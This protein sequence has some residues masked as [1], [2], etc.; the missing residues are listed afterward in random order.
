[1]RALL[2]ALI[3]VLI[4]LNYQLWIPENQGVRQMQMLQAAIKDQQAENE[5]LKQR[6]SGL[7]AE[8]N[9]LKE[10]L[11]AIEERAR[12]NLGMISK[13][14]TFFRI[15]DDS[16]PSSDPTTDLEKTSQQ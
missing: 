13:G 3:C 2:A 8:V 14:E 7:E 16:L 10:G 1:M 9:S 5:A 11:E 15:L 6:N 4:I 12:A